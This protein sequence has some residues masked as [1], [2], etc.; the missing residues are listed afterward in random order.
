MPRVKFE[1][2]KEQEMPLEEHEKT[3]K[4]K[5]EGE[6]VTAIDSQENRLAKVNHPL[7]PRQFAAAWRG[8]KDIDG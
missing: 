3:G 7:D 2:E 6:E 8:E 4:E 1:W 5:L